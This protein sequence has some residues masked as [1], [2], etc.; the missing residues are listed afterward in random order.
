[1]GEGEREQG[2]GRASGGSPKRRRV[3]EGCPGGG[4]RSSR[5][6][7]SGRGSGEASV[8]REWADALA[9]ICREDG[10]GELEPVR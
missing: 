4:G 5:P 3:A 10:A 7:G 8:H 2:E 6:P 1:M 9:V